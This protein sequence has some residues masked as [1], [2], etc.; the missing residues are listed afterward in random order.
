M[1]AVKRNGLRRPD[2]R[3]KVPADTAAHGHLK[4]DYNLELY[5][6]TELLIFFLYDL[7]LTIFFSDYK[8]PEKCHTE[9]GEIILK[10][11]NS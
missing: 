7:I 11:E 4:L 8:T 6:E 1:T 2:R 9:T 5:N 3:V 10:I